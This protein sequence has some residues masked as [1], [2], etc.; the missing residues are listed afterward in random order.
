[1]IEVIAEN[2]EEEIYLTVDGQKAVKVG[3]KDRI[4]IKRSEKQVSI[5][6]LDDYD[7]YKVLR[8]KIL[9]NTNECDGE[10]L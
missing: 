2:D 4:T 1:L 9:K 3:Q 5:I 7:Y 8:S 10:M 6:L